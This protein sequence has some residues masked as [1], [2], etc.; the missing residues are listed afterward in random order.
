MEALLAMCC[1]K[2]N[3]CDREGDGGRIGEQD[4]NSEKRL[5]GLRKTNNEGLGNRF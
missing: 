5:L 1:E 4:V 3:R 2:E